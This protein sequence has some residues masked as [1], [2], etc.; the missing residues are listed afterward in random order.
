MLLLMFQAMLGC[1]TFK[2][3]GLE[4]DDLQQIMFEAISATNETTYEPG[5]GHGEDVSS[6]RMAWLMV[7]VMLR[8]VQNMSQEVLTKGQLH[9]LGGPQVPHLE[10]EKNH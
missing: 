6:M 5:T 2:T 7:M 4:H 9:L 8:E 3:S 1:I 10:R